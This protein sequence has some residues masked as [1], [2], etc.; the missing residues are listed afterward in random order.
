MEALYEGT[1]S[2]VHVGVPHHAKFY[3]NLVIV[4]GVIVI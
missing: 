1:S 2:T 4:C 3:Q